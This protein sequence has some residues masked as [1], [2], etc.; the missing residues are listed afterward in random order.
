MVLNM[1]EIDKLIRKLDGWLAKS[2][3]LK[4]RAEEKLLVYAEMPVKKFA[5]VASE[6]AANYVRVP[7]S[8]SMDN[9]GLWHASY[10][11][12]QI[13]QEDLAFSESFG[14]SAGYLYLSFITQAKTFEKGIADRCSILR[15]WAAT[16]YF[17]LASCESDERFKEIANYIKK[18]NDNGDLKDL[19]SKA[20]VFCVALIDIE[21]DK[22]EGALNNFSIARASLKDSTGALSIYEKMIKKFNEKTSSTEYS[23]LVSAA[24]DVHIKEATQAENNIEF[25]DFLWEPWGI[26]PCEV[27]GYANMVHKKFGIEVEFPSTRLG[28]VCRFFMTNL[29]VIKY[30]D[31][32]DAVRRRAEQVLLL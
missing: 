2:D 6:K 13:I 7:S 22:I 1:K 20:A 30:D 26:V 25:F 31:L 17:L 18:L 12:K 23:E 11:A 28:D 27:I 15:D 16:V 10:G 29:P 3:N 21:C 9:L 5:S 19:G 4:Q 14:V 8:I 24:L 32:A